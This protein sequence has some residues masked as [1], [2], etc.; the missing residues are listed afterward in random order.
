MAALDFPTSPLPGQRYPADP[1][2]TGVSQW[3]W[4]NT[5]GVWNTVSN[6]VRLNNQAAFNGYAWPNTDGGPGQQLETDGAGNLYWDAASDPTLVPLGLL[7]PFDNIA[8]SFTIINPATLAAYT[9]TPSS[10]LVVILGGVLQ[11]PNTAYTVAGSTLN[12]TNPPQTG[13]DFVAF[14]VEQQ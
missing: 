4:D 5:V 9:P 3:E 12:F 6:F 10:N 13:T 14:T 2:T 7:Q 11:T 1:G 8:T